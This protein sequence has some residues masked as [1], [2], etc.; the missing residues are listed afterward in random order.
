MFLCLEI[1]CN[2]SWKNATKKKTGVYIYIVEF[3]GEQKISL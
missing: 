3:Y 2:S 1:R